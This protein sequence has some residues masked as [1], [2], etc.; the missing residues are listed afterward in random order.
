M[1]SKI[2]YFCV[3]GYRL[4]C[5]C[6]IWRLSPQCYRPRSGWTIVKHQSKE[7]ERGYCGELAMKWRWLVIWL[8]CRGNFNECP[9]N[10]G[11][12]GGTLL[13][14]RAELKQGKYTPFHTELP[15]KN[16]SVTT[17][18]VHLVTTNDWRSKEASSGNNIILVV[19]CHSCILFWDWPSSLARRTNLKSCRNEDSYRGNV[20]R[21]LK[22][23][24]WVRS[25]GEAASL[26]N[27]K[28][29]LLSGILL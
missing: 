18:F 22:Y 4:Q 11:L 8:C 9:S 6:A 10:W 12:S 20:D 17:A 24:S 25:L 29:L 3:N 5:I 14:W 19:F 1:T 13:S 27:L 21:P 2:L 28:S 7:P 16:P 23:I 26:I 15:I